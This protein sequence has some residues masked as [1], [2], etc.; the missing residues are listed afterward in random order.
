MTQNENSIFLIQK[1]V[2]IGSF[3]IIGIQNQLHISF[4]THVC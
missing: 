1:P 4:G 3:M 2:L